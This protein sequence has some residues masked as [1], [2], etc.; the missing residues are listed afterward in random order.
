MSEP[1]Y[2]AATKLSIIG[3][4]KA[5]L[6]AQANIKGVLSIYKS[7]DRLAEDMK[8]IEIGQKGFVFSYTQNGRIVTHPNKN[9]FFKNVTQM[10]EDR[11][12]YFSAHK[13]MMEQ[14][15]GSTIMDVAGTKSV[16]IW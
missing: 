8:R 2:D 11:K 16:V 15:S 14:T 4:S 5:T 10:K 1:H 9:Y 6:D 7:I 3:F 13:A 12:P